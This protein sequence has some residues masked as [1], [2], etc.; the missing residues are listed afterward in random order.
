MDEPCDLIDPV[1]AT[2]VDGDGKFREEPTKL[3]VKADG[4]TLRI[5]TSD[6]RLF[7][8]GLHSVLSQILDPFFEGG[9]F[10]ED[11]AMPAVEAIGEYLRC[12]A[13][14]TK[15]RIDLARAAGEAVDLDPYDVS[16]ARRKD[17]PWMIKPV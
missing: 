6:G 7:A 11:D 13:G 9:Q 12:V 14:F 1:E 3:W 16:H 2:P 10:I 4:L 15:G 5:E 8:V 17:L